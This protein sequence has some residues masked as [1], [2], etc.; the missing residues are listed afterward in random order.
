MLPLEKLIMEAACLYCPRIVSKLDFVLVVVVANDLKW[1]KTQTFKPFVEVNLI[2]PH[3]ADKKRRQ[4]TKIKQ[5]V[6]SPKFNETFTFLFGNEDALSVYEL[7]IA[8]KDHCFGF[9]REDRLVG[10]A[11]VQLKDI[12]DQVSF[13]KGHP[14]CILSF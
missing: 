10:V 5:S 2:G 8:V 12:E 9:G 14:A 6:W 11:V 1:P 3:L 13:Y 7:H 4:V